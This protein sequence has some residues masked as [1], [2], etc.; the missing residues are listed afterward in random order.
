M[1]TTARMTTVGVARLA[2]RG[3]FIEKFAEIPIE[4]SRGSAQRRGQRRASPTSLGEFLGGFG[5]EFAE[6]AEEDRGYVADEAVRHRM[7]RV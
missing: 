4:I 6:E 3:T 2:K 5:G 7:A 1:T